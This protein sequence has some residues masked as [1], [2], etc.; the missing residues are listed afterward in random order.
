MVDI[1]L[2][3]YQVRTHIEQLWVRARRAIAGRIL[4]DVEALAKRQRA[5]NAFLVKQLR[6][7]RRTFDAVNK[8][9]TEQALISG[10]TRFGTDLIRDEALTYDEVI[11]PTLGFSAKVVDHELLI[12]DLDPTKPVRLDIEPD[13][14]DLRLVVLN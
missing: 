5:D 4:T 9:A 2:A 7:L 8:R 6:D 12:R 14:D 13:A 1:Q 10:R 11:F 3:Y